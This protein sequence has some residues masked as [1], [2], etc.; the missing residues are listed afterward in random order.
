MKFQI[1]LAVAAL[2]LLWRRWRMI[3]GFTISGLAVL[4]PSIWLVGLQGMF[5]HTLL[6]LG[7]VN[8]LAT[9][10]DQSMNGIFPQA[11]PNLG[12]LLFSLGGARQP[13]F[14]LQAEIA[15]VSLLVLWWTARR[16]KH[17][18]SQGSAFALAIV[19]ESSRNMAS[20]SKLDRASRQG[21][22]NPPSRFVVG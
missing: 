11:M 7:A 17:I 4:I 20:L 14:W 9:S 18:R 16:G 21:V 8:G 5:T 12:G 13:K 22:V 2:F 6:L 3:G 15:G 1:A 10:G 19:C